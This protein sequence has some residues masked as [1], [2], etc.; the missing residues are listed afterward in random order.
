MK[1]QGAAAS[2]Y[3]AAPDTTKAA[4]LIHGDDAS[5]VQQKRAQA[6]AALAGPGAEAEMRLTR[7]PASE[8]RRDPAA[9]G[10]AMRSPAFFPGP[11]VVVVDDATD[12]LAPMLADA[13]ADWRAGDAHLILTAAALPAK[14][15]LRKV[16]E[17]HAACVCIAVYDDPPGPDEVV[18]ELARAGLSRPGADVLA[19]IVALGRS[20]D[21]G[22]FR[23]TL[24]RV[25][26][27]KLGDSAPLTVAE[28]EAV[29]PLTAE[30]DDTD[31]A[32][33]L[34]EDR[35]GDIPRLLRRLIGQGATPVGTVLALARVL[36]AM[37]GTGADSGTLMA[38]GRGLPFALRD[39]LASAAR[40]WPASRVEQ[41]LAE[42]LETDATLRSSNPTPGWPM[43]ERT[44][45]RIAMRNR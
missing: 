30:A 8:A 9:L 18:S 41:A 35:A 24:E 10:D 28:V 39:V 19:E 14:S 33:A 22:D 7:L 3:L 29:A 20:L 38:R 32:Q 44:L 13:L 21:A 34:I 5:R 1:L 40:N 12:G 27:Y 43:V 36:R 26:L 16:A 37:P 2:R 17:D 4:L 15:A 45:L 25:A 42:L 23:R 6:A 31:L 11:R